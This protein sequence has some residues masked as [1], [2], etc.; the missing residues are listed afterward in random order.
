MWGHQN[1]NAPTEFDARTVCAE[2]RASPVDCALSQTN[3]SGGSPRAANA[4]DYGA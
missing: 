2:K 3:F 4:S 1:S